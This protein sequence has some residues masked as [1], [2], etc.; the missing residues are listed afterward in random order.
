MQ[1]LC[2]KHGVPFNIFRP[3]EETNLLAE[4]VK[5]ENVHIPKECSVVAGCVLD[6]TAPSETILASP[7]CEKNNFG[8]SLET[9]ESL[10]NEYYTATG[11][12]VLNFSTDGDST[13]RQVFT[14]L[15]SHDLDP[16]SLLG[17]IIS[18]FPLVDELCGIQQ[19]TVSYDPKHLCKRCWASLTKESVC[20][21]NYCQKGRFE[22][23]VFLVTKCKQFGN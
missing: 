11:K 15:L 21:R 7:T 16:S 4:A 10:A 1:G 17:E 18:G 19:E 6:D 9:F 22:N 23:T 2:S 8:Q 14:K 20:F 3:Y 12:P 13:R 5:V